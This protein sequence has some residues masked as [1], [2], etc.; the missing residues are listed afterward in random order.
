MWEVPHLGVFVYIWIRPLGNLF[1][2]VVMLRIGLF[3]GR[4]FYFDL[5]W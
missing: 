2:L 3:A 4:W 1:L 5:V